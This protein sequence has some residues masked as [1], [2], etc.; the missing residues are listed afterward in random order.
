MRG[1]SWIR[2]IS[3]LF[4]FLAICFGFF[5]TKVYAACSGAD[6]TSCEGEAGCHWTDVGCISKTKNALQEYIDHI[7]DIALVVGGVAAVAMLVY[8]GIKYTT[9]GGDPAK[10]T[11]AKDIAVSTIIGLVVLLLAGLIIAL[12]NPNA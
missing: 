6:K 8:A 9:S 1:K 12:I 5:A 4:Y 10:I 3:S 11:E 7:Y 2:K